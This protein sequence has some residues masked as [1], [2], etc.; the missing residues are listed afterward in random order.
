MIF[1]AMRH[2]YEMQPRTTYH[3]W[4]LSKQTKDEFQL[5]EMEKDKNQTLSF[6]QAT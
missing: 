3:K 2:G 6:F 4:T 5:K 1:L